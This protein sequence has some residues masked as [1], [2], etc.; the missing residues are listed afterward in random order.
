MNKQIRTKIRG[1][2]RDYNF[3]SLGAL[4]VAIAI[5]LFLGP[6]QLAFGGV[7][8][9]SIIVEE[10]FNIPLNLTYYILSI[11]LLL[12][13][14]FKKGKDFFFKTLFASTVISFIFIPCTNFLQEFTANINIIVAA[15][16]GAVFLGGGVGIILRF[17]G[18]SAG[19]DL[20]AAMLNKFI[21]E[22]IT[23]LA[24][25]GVIFTCGLI[26]FGF[27]N[28]YSLIVLVVT[29]FTVGVVLNPKKYTG[30]LTRLRIF[31]RLRNTSE[32]IHDPSI[33]GE[34]M[35]IR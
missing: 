14:R 13:G 20:I 1:H 21:P 26:V 12:L 24:I 30:I 19:P 34:G 7:T 27:T 15:F 33:K 18:S 10:L 16:T 5:N 9:I 2:L 6:F 35:L 3:I 32:P 25:D 23:M 8:G 4:F 29:P 11:V 17:K 31:G 28:F 22:Q